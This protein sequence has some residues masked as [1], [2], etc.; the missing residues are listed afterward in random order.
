MLE[1]TQPTNP[2]GNTGTLPILNLLKAKSQFRKMGVTI[3]KNNEKKGTG[4]SWKFGD[5]EHIL[6]T[7]N[8]PLWECGLEIFTTT[9][10]KEDSRTYASVT[11]V[12]ADSGEY[13]VSELP[14]GTIEPKKF[15]NGATDYLGAELD[16][17]K[18]FTVMTRILIMR[19]LN[20][21]D[22]E[23]PEHTNHML[24]TDEELKEFNLKQKEKEDSEKKER[25]EKEMKAV[26]TVNDIYSWIDT[27][28]FDGVEV[29][30][31]RTVAK[32]RLAIICRDKNTS[33]SNTTDY[34]RTVS[35][36][37][38]AKIKKQLEIKG[39]SNT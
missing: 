39:D 3:S 37:T 29:K 14:F 38:L 25:K 24:M 34:L 13:I 30:A 1:Q 35:E 4:G 7:I 33:T 2:L 22:N 10:T 32:T 27:I 17:A 5:E 31:R 16:R 19:M 28:E 8:Y 26:R 23:S 18:Q 11:L 9:A 12:H 36:D 15:S 6:H 20:L 21:T